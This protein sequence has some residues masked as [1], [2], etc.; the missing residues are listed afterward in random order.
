MY[1]LTYIN[2]YMFIIFKYVCTVFKNTNI[3]Y[4]CTVHFEALI[5][6]YSIS[7]KY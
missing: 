2:I 7:L 6:F 4:F 1:A 3:V 5:P